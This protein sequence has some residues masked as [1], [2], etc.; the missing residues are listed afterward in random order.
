MQQVA[1]QL[2]LL[3]QLMKVFRLGLRQYF[4]VNTNYGPQL[5]QHR[6]RPLLRHP[7]L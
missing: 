1:D 6:C 7:R 3:Q 4:A 2:A 5:L